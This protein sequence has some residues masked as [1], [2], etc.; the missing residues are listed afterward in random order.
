MFLILSWSVGDR[1]KYINGEFFDKDTKINREL[2]TVSLIRSKHLIYSLLINLMT[3]IKENNIKDLN[4][5]L[6]IY[7]IIKLLKSGMKRY[8]KIDFVKL[9]IEKISSQKEN[10]YENPIGQKFIDENIEFMNDDKYYGINDQELLNLRENWSVKNPSDNL[11]SYKNDKLNM[12]KNFIDIY[13]TWKSLKENNII[14]YIGI[15]RKIK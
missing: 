9:F 2:F 3:S 13:K 12:F 4:L 5:Y 8:I 7:D 11:R 15:R 10:K 1:F 6:Q 14:K